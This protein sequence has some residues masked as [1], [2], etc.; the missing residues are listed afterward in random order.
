VKQGDAVHFVADVPHVYRNPGPIETVMYL[1][2]T[3]ALR[4]P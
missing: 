3:Y 2:M 1:V 4:E